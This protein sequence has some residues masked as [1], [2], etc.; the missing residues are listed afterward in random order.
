[1]AGDGSQWLITQR[2]VGAS[3]TR[4]L[5]TVM[6]RGGAQHGDDS[7]DAHKD[8]LVQVGS[9]QSLTDVQNR[10]NYSYEAASRKV[11]QS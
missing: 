11:E 2:P 3:W 5:L 4:G 7:G 8:S 10:N 9:C 6:A 1:M